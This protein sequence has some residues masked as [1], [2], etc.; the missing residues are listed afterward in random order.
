[1]SLHSLM[2][3][4]DRHFDNMLDL[5]RDANAK[6][7]FARL[8]H[9]ARALAEMANINGYH[10]GAREHDDYRNWAAQLKQQAIQF[11]DLAKK[12]DIAAARKLAGK[13]NKTCKA[14]HDKY[15]D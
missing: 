6:K 3:E 9:E 15:Q 12:K 5:L 13:M 1:M 4:Q 2:D 11:A 10:K 7:R 14:C 8:D